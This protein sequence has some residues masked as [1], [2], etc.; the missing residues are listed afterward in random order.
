[1]GFPP[2]MIDPREDCR[3]WA[4]LS[5]DNPL[6]GKLFLVETLQGCHIC[7]MANNTIDDEYIHVLFY[8]TAKYMAELFDINKN[9]HI[10]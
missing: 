4:M 7:I 3:P 9:K 1:M 8:I 5:I 10:S 6:S 2:G